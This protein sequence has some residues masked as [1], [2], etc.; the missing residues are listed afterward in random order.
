MALT[1]SEMKFYD[2]LFN[3]ICPNA[4]KKTNLF[5]IKGKKKDSVKKK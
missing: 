3:N 4:T 5:V 1:R 2:K